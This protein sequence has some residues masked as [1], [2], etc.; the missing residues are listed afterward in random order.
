MISFSCHLNYKIALYN[1]YYLKRNSF[2]SRTQEINLDS[3]FHYE[4]FTFIVWED[5]IERSD[6]RYCLLLV[7]W[8]IFFQNNILDLLLFFIC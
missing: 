7:I 6:L 4:I 5:Q 8:G 1:F 2:V 3:L